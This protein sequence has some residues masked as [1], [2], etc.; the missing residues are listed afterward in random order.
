MYTVYS[1]LLGL[2]L[3]AF[4]PYFAYQAFVNKK[5]FS[6]LRERLGRL[7]PG[8]TGHSDRADQAAPTIWIHAVSVG[9]TL[10]AKPL[11]TALRERLPHSRVV[12]ST[13]TMTGQAV[14][15]SRIKDASGFCYF[16]LDWRFAVRRA[17]NTIR[18]ET[19]VLMESELWPN[20]LNE[21]HSRQI[22]VVV[23]NGRISDR[24]LERW[25]RFGILARRMFQQVSCFAMQ[26][27]ADAERAV[28]LGAAAENVF[29]SGNIK[30]DCGDDVLSPADESTAL[31]FDHALG[32]DQ[33]PLIVAGSTCDGEEEILIAALEDLRKIEGLK[34][35]RMLLAPRHP[36]RF[37]AVA[38]LLEG[39]RLSY[40]R[41]SAVV[42][43][44]EPAGVAAPQSQSTKTTAG[45]RREP[46]ADVILL[47]SIGEL[48]LLYRF[49][50]VVFVGGSLIVKG[51]H[52]ILEPA[53]FAKPI[54]VGP[55]MENFG[56]ITDEFNRRAALV[57]L[58]GT[59]DRQLVAELRDTLSMLLSDEERSRRLG[60]NALGAV[61][62]NRGATLRTSAAIEK[63]IS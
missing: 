24:S 35:V 42:L 18:P 13:T 61:A 5:Y 51:G 38:R 63:L 1:L 11:V 26:T 47:D 36:E 16:P 22:P 17:L 58:H 21:C 55:H 59:T 3:I 8:L 40:R 27:P 32:L 2:A 30:Y 4:L 44:T 45:W 56:E 12:I 48:A 23:A 37:D 46:P 60:E 28:R 43:Q 20:F 19:V 6:N 9:E 31:A 52:N 10:A 50:S 54:V 14:A 53:R 7:P 25:R 49:A 34:G 15:R 33:A 62:E 39:S 41:R 57:Q 29:V